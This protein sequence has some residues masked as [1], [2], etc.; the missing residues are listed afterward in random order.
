MVVKLWFLL[1]LEQ[2]PSDES[3]TNLA[4]TKSTI[5]YLDMIEELR[6]DSQMKLA[7]Y[8]QRVRR[9]YNNKVKARPFKVGDLVL[10]K[11]IPNTKV[12]AHGAF[13]A[14]WEGPYQIKS[15]IWE[16]TYHLMDMDGN[17]IPKAWNA[18]HLKKYYQ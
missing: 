8:Q 3:T 2:V 15:A 16:G 12:L 14:N 7:S 4:T 5:L 1:K 10:R 17:L 18:E 11:V 9:Y 13:G 6:A